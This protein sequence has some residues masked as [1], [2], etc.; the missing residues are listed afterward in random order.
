MNDGVVDHRVGAGG[1]SEAC[2]DDRAPLF[3]E[4]D[5]SLNKPTTP[6]LLFIIIIII[7]IIHTYYIYKLLKTCCPDYLGQSVSATGVLRLLDH[8]CG[9]CCQ[10][11]YGCVTVSDSLNGCCRP[12]CFVF[13]TA[14][15]CVALVRSAVYKSS[16]LLTSTHL[17]DICV[18]PTNYYCQNRQ[19]EQ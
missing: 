11:I 7:I 19:Q 10:Y 9:T 6:E 2:V 18:S 14:A 3:V 17:P 8:V 1:L 13:V 12:I 4:T 15:L 16:Y 5:L